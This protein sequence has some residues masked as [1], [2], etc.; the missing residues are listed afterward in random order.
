MAENYDITLDASPVG[1]AQV[2]KQGLY[3]R[4]SCRCKLPDNGFYRIHVICGDKREDLGICVPMGDAF[5]MDKKLP[6]KKLGE[7]KPT[8]ELLPRDWQPA[9]LPEIQEMPPEEAETPEE[10]TAVEEHPVEVP[11]EETP[12]EDSNSVPES[13]EA[14]ADPE[15]A[16]PVFLPVSEEEPFGHLDELGNAV[17]EVRDGEVGILLAEKQ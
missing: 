9:R 2:E 11:A 3:Y 14:S 5:G 16:E 4:F 6:A 15:T 13:C 8:F 1:S 17:M 7:G 10:T 12:V